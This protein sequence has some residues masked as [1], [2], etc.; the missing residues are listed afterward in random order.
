MEREPFRRAWSVRAVPPSSVGLLADLILLELLVQIAARRADHF[1][2]LRDVPAVLA[3]L[4]DEEHALGVLLELA[5]GARLRRVAV[6]GL[7]RRGRSAAAGPGTW[8]AD[9][10][11]QVSEV[12]R[13]AAGHD[14]HPLDGV[15][16]LADVAAPAVA[17]QRV[18][19]RLRDPLRP[20]VVVAAE[21]VHVVADQRR[22]VLGPLAQRR[23]GERDY[24]EAGGAVPWG[25]ATP[26]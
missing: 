20:H 19:R 21:G 17:G 23:G 26:H 7:F 2:R 1:R 15:A 24:R 9:G 25:G 22:D 4:A 16:Q 18:E 10:F 3:Q 5:Q 12:D 14:D 11:R 13:V 8:R 6:T